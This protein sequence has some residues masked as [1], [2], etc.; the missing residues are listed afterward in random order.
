MKA[1]GFT[2]RLTRLGGWQMT[3]HRCRCDRCMPAERFGAGAAVDDDLVSIIL[4]G[5]GPDIV[6][7]PDEPMDA[8]APPPP[9]DVDGM[10]AI[11][12]RMDDNLRGAFG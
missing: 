3:Y 8:V 7:P 5:D 1:K 10:R 6:T 9:P 4:S 2:P 11:R 12:K